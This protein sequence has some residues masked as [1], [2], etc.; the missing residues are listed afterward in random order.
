[1]GIPTISYNGVPNYIEKYLVRVGLVKRQAN[2]RKI[3]LLIQKMMNQGEVNKKKADSILASMED[4][5]LKLVE[6]IKI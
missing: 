4:P 6:V 5:Y 2:S 1:M 3:S